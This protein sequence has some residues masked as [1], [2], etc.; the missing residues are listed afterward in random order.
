[1]R[2]RQWSATIVQKVLKL[3][4]KQQRFGDNN[5][6][7]NDRPRFGRPREIDRE[8]VID[9]IDPDPTLTTRDLTDCFE[10]DRTTIWR[11]LKASGWKWR[12]GSWFPHLLTE[13]RKRQSQ[14]CASSFE[15]LAPSTLERY[16]YRGWK[17]GVICYPAPNSQLSLLD[18]RPVQTPRHDF[19]HCKVMLISFWKRENSFIGG[20]DRAE[21]HCSEVCREHLDLCRRALSRRCRSVISLQHKARRTR[22]KFRA[23]GWEWLEHTPY[24]PDLSPSDYHL[25]KS[26]RSHIPNSVSLD[27]SNTF[28]IFFTF[29]FCTC[30]S[31]F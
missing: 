5:T 26:I 6:E 28:L 10:Y 8:A 3:R 31:V 11:A 2:K 19:H 24:S 4:Q 25:F 14:N 22:A 18:Q 9:L 7:L 20:F 16:R 27:K 30:H 21:T 13:A 1:M 17:V 12:K 15:S 29:I 23:M